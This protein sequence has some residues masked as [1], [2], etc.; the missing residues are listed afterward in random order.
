MWFEGKWM[1]LED[2]MLSE[3]SQAQKDK[4][5]IFSLMLEIDTVQMQAILWKTD[6]AKGRSLTGEGELKKEVK[7]VNMVDVLSV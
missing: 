3:V 4:G 7:K 1:Q 6:H 5:H 2:I